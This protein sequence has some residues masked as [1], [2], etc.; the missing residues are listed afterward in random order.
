MNPVAPKTTVT[1]FM[2]AALVLLIGGC[3]G[4]RA[5][6]AP[7]LTL[8]QAQAPIDISCRLSV[9]TSSGAYASRKMLLKAPWSVAHPA[10][11]T[12]QALAVRW[13]DGK[14]PVPARVMFCALPATS[15]AQRWFSDR[16]GE[17]D[18]AKARMAGDLAKAARMSHPPTKSPGG[19]PALLS[20]ESGGAM[21]V[22][23]SLE[24]GDEECG[25][26]WWYSGEG[27]TCN[28]EW[29]FSVALNAVSSETDCEIDPGWGG[30]D[31]G[32]GESS[33][34]SDDRTEETDIITNTGTTDYPHYSTH[35]P[36]TVNVEGRT[37]SSITENLI[38]VEVTLW[39]QR[40]LLWTP[41]CTWWPVAVGAPSV[42]LND[43]EVLGNAARACKTGW[44]FGESAHYAKTLNVHPDYVKTSTSAS[45]H[46]ECSGP[47]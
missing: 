19:N 26:E 1:L 14:A 27:C 8:T 33:D 23:N 10:K 36:G 5:P 21:F 11:L 39:G 42:K 30:P 20:Q 29:P 37:T 25:G 6:T 43:S 15:A 12:T 44:Y 47:T 9:L 2:V 46:V 41:L 24:F 32:M 13:K 31:P 18:A 28:E 4:D 22:L 16:F 34:Y 7:A 3:T 17:P 35:V 45:R 38:S 40:C